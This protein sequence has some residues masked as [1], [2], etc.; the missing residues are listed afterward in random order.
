MISE[1]S[2]AEENREE[3]EEDGAEEWHAR[4]ALASGE[5]GDGGDQACHAD[6][7]SDAVEEHHRP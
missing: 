4:T 6:T 5:G 1:T 7:L 2:P 3:A